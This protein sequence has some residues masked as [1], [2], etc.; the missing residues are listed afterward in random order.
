M[1]G[2]G[3]FSR[4]AA[5]LADLGAWVWVTLALSIAMNILSFT[6]PLFMMQ[7]MDSVIPARDQTTLFI[8]LGFGG[9]AFALMTAIEALRRSLVTKAA[10]WTEARLTAII[11]GADDL[12]APTNTANLGYVRQISAFV[13]SG[14]TTLLD[15][16]ISIISFAILWMIHPI[17]AA[18]GV[19]TTLIIV[20][21]SYFA[22]RAST[23]GAAAANEQ[24]KQAIA[25]ADALGDAGAAAS[26]MGIAR[27]IEHKFI[28]EFCSSLVAD[29]N[30]SG[31]GERITAFAKFVRQFAQISVLAMGA[32]F[33]MVG[34]IS[35]GAMIAASI[36][37]GKALAPF[38]QL[39]GAW[40]AFT[41]ALQSAQILNDDLA[42]TRA[43]HDLEKI[44]PEK[45]KP[46]L[47]LENITVPRG[48]GAKPILDRIDFMLHPGECLAL[49]GPSGSGKTTLGEIIV[50]ASTAR[51][52][53]ISIDGIPYNQ[54]SDEQ[55]SELFGYVPQSVQFFPGTIS[56]NV[57]RFDP[58]AKPEDVLDAVHRSETEDLIRDLPDGF[59]TKIDARGRPLSLG[60]A[61]RVS[62]ARAIYGR[63]KLVV[64]DEPTSDLDPVGEKALISLIG[65]LK[66]EGAGV[67]LIAQRAG[68]L[69][70][71]DKMMQL[72]SGRLRDFG[73]KN[74]VLTRLS[75]RRPQIDL[76]P[77]LD[78]TPRLLHW[79][80]VHLSRVGD[81]PMRARAEIALVEIFNMLRK[82]P[83]IDDQEKISVM[84]TRTES[85]PRFDVYSAA[86][87][88]I[89]D[90]YRDP[91]TGIIT[92]PIDQDIFDI[93]NFD[94]F[95]A[96]SAANDL[97]EEVQNDRLRIG[98]FI[99]ES[100]D[101]DR[102]L[103]Q[104]MSV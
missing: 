14:A 80:S 45:I 19:G 26:V 24:R 20:T 29:V 90:E 58:N 101:E 68:L 59:D 86:T 32:V 15:A 73:E 53:A 51:M 36:I 35:G 88:P 7:I 78:E 93:E 8:L 102:A 85:D 75:M 10:I 72:D 62:L 55:K 84:I 67:V 96:L 34:E 12:K 9:G 40:S 22:S 82:R 70:V 27:N 97:E 17:F 54:I 65:T 61:R 48:L 21:A 41:S 49:V 92:L 50:G 76:T 57:S 1:F 64:L 63:P 83:D 28:N 33:V 13:R 60:N 4:L 66:S 87:T 39:L 23:G 37:L 18:L 5:T 104:K 11:F 69:A 25:L 100:L 3:R 91:F 77:A 95:V 74:E 44:T 98:F 47:R 42:S 38:D 89:F 56:E 2:V 46:L 30:A 94:K 103:N 31:A 43:Q 71:A 81:G 99:R 79:L 52:G 6:S 16:P